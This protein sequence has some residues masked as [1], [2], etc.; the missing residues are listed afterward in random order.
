MYQN[1]VVYDHMQASLDVGSLLERVIVVP[2]VVD[3]GFLLGLNIH[4][5]NF[6]R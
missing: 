3:K 5:I 1:R 4:E 6:Q 2:T